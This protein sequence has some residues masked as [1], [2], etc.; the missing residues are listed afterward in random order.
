MPKSQ[1]PCYQLGRTNFHTVIEQTKKCHI[2]ELLPA[3]KLKKILPIK[4]HE[5]EMKDSI[6]VKA[7]LQPEKGVL[8]RPA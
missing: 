8:P 4:S 6:K 7:H 1:Q 2:L 3:I 5:D